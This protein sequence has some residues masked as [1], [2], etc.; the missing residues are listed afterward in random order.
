MYKKNFQPSP[1]LMNAV[2]LCIIAGL[3]LFVYW[4][5][6]NHQYLNFDDNVYVSL[7][8]YVKN[9]F[10]LENIKWAFTFTDI[11]YWHPLTW[12]SHMLDCQL[13][14]VKPGPQLLINLAI[15]IF[16]TL[17]LFLIISKMTGAQFKAA[18][19]AL[20]FAF[21][22]LNVESVAWL[23][24]RKTVLSTLFLFGAI[25]TYLHY[26]EKKKKWKYALILFLYAC[27]LMS[28]PMILTFPVLLLLL[29]YW[30]LKRFERVAAI[31]YENTAIVSKPVNRF[32]LL[33][34][35]D[36][37]SIIVEKIPLLIL[38]LFS[39]LVTMASVLHSRFLVTHDL[40]PIYLR[41]Y[42]YF[43]SITQYLQYIAWPV[44]L[45]IFYPFPKTFIILY[46]L[47]ALSFVVSITI[48]AF[49][50]RKKRPWLI[51]GWLWF[52]VA[53]LP[54]SGLIQA[55]LWPA[56]ANRFMYIPMIGIF[57]MVIWE[58]DERLKGSYS[59]VLKVILYGVMLTYFAL[60]TRTQN[61]YFSNSFALFNRCL[62]VAGDNSLALNNLGETLVS[63]GRTDEALIYFT[64]N[65]KLNPTQANTYHN[66]GVCL[67]AKKDD[68]KAIVYFQK[69]I[70][71]NPNLVQPLI[72]LSLIQSRAGNDAE[73]VKFM[74]KALA[75]DQN[76]LDAHNNYGFILAKRGKYEEAIA[77]FLFVIKRDPGNVP[78][79]LNLAQAYQDAGLYNEAMVQYETLNKI[80]KHNKGYVYYG[81]AGVYSQQKK[82]E[83]C[84]AYLEISL[85]DGFN[86]L[87]Y[88]KSDN[89]FKNFRKT[90]AYGAFLENH[91]TKIP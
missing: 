31:N 90:P 50:A 30:P 24:E 10:S 5:I 83:E 2:I 86:V 51:I 65:I 25:Y 6:Q 58:A 79:W 43:V 27:G 40:V 16:N 47:G 78:A 23:A 84:A 80:I 44:N 77:H 36:I 63:L 81:I 26:T 17:L 73:A 49:I 37:G 12:L 85:K 69:A 1:L 18:F 38:S 48:L 21:H 67:V 52:L 11:S 55:G 71:L 33:C 64:K 53:L 88:L 8:P 87:E 89:R 46:F 34:K 28:K 4:D 57:I 74:E 60:L 76:N 68:E 45:S 54:A 56:L 75:I 91:K 7:N 32:I 22:P 70:A 42:N 59:Q 13:F 39:I 41:I 29:D 14:G 9:G 66:Y 82:Y 61:V 20:L 62:E 19:V 72:H 15:H 35:S 3:T